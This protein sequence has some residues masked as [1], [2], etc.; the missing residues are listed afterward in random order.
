M[1]APCL[2]DPKVRPTDGVLAGHLKSRARLWSAFTGM[3]QADPAGLTLQWRYYLDGKRWLGKVQGKKKTVCWISIEPGWFKVTFYLGSKNDAAVASARIAPALKR[4]FSRSK[5]KSFRP[6]TVEVRA[7][8]ALDDVRE[9]L[10][11][12]TGAGRRKP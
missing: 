4:A 12:A 5:G 6:L 3:I 11:L 9:V 1:T 8:A 2:D 10:A 7:A